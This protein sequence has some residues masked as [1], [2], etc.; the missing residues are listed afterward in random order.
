V[1]FELT[2]HGELGTLSDKQKDVVRS[3]ITDALDTL[4]DPNHPM[5]EFKAK[6]TTS[7]SVEV[8]VTK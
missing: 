2:L 8:E 3:Q 1:T 4:L 6:I 7:K 5:P